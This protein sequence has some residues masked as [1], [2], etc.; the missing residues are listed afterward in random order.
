MA[1]YSLLSSYAGVESIV[2]SPPDFPLL[3]A[4]F[5][6]TK[7]H[8]DDDATP[9]CTFCSTLSVLLVID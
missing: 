3:I 6:S 1:N 7:V 9:L 2:E 8:R 4:I 5:I